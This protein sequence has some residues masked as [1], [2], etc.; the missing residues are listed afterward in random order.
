[1]A[2]MDMGIF[3][4]VEAAQEAIRQNHP[5]IKNYDSPWWGDKQTQS[6]NMSNRGYVIGFRDPS[7]KAQWRLDY[8]P[9]KKV[10][11][12]WT[13]EV[14]GSETLKEC[15]RITSYVFSKDENVW[16]YYAAWTKTRFNDIPPEIKSRLDAGGITSWN[17]KVWQRVF[18]GEQ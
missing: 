13:Q 7:S 9:I 3:S 6:G 15:Y 16:L 17:G 12:N 18:A 2:E 5:K 8:D 11:I 4:S 10:H 14:P 1:M